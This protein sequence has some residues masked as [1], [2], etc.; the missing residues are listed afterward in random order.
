MSIFPQILR[1]SKI[2]SSN[3]L[4]GFL[5]IASPAM[6][7]VTDWNLYLAL[8]NLNILGHQRQKKDLRGL[9]LDFGFEIYLQSKI[10]V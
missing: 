9:V 4:I 8:L 10:Y 3:P 1:R 6:L 7:S 5:K 2:I